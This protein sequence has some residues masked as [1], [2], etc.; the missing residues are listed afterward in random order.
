MVGTVVGTGIYLKPSIVARLLAEPWQVL[1]LWAVAGVFVTSGAVVYSHLARVWPENGG[2][3][4]YLHRV[5]GPWAASL[6]LAADV[7]LARPAAVGALSYGLGL[8]WQL[9]TG[10]CL[11]LAMTTLAV[12][13]LLQLAGAR[14]QGVGQTALTVLQLLPLLGVL[15]LAFF[16]QPSSPIRSTSGDSPVAWGGAF[17]AVLWAY[18]GWYN[19]TNLSGEVEEPDRNLPLALIGGM[20]FVTALYLAVN[21]VLLHSLGMPALSRHSLPLLALL[22]EWGL[23]WLGTGIQV[24]LSTALLA[25]LNGTQ[26][27]G[28][29]VMVAAAKDGLLHSRLGQDPTKPVPTLAFSFY[30][31]GILALFGGLPLSGNLFDILTEF[32]AVVVLLLSNLTVTCLFRADKLRTQIPGVAYAAATVYLLANTWLAWLLVQE[33]NLMAALGAVGVL[34]VGTFLWVGRQR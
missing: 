14:V 26:A 11:A 31:L 22:E 2:A 17:L 6:L 29:R 21:A 5:Y 34:I 30:C 16:E 1:L 25:T 19:L 24:A 3:Y 18:D 7:F 23:S 15:L 20:G 33:A 9:P 13:T 4:L 27:C 8:I 10:Q 12:L 32:T 28:S